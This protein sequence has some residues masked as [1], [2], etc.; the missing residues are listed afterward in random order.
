MSLKKTIKKEIET[1]FPK[2]YK[3]KNDSVLDFY[4]WVNTRNFWAI[5]FIYFVSV[6]IIGLYTQFIDFDFLKILNI[7]FEDNIKTFTT[8][9]ITLVSMNL[10]VTNLLFTHLKDERDDIQSIIDKKVNFKFI[11]YLGFSIIVCILSLY[12]FSPNIFN[13]NVKSNI[14]IF[15]FCSFLCYIFLLIIL[16]NTVFNF[17]HKTKRTEIIKTELKLE[18]HKAFYNDYYKK[19]FNEE[20]K[21]L[22]ENK[23]NFSHY[24]NWR[25]I[26]GIEH[27]KINNSKDIYLEDIN[28]TSNQFDKVKN[29]E[30]FY[31]IMELGK[32][33]QKNT[34]IRLFSVSDKIKF[35]YK[36]FYS[37]STKNS[38]PLESHREYLDKLLKKVTDNTLTNRYT[39]L[40][41][42]LKSL[43]D[44]YSEYIDLKS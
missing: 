43:E 22:M 41:T 8:G 11:T 40:S 13:G 15:I 6:L 4:T 33:Y 25:E 23:L 30:K 27:L 24:S 20:Y 29:V 16:Y 34:D 28:D 44:I 5:L 26:E 38:F 39:D 36:R 9:I 7:K 1:K 14:L 19:R 31:H 12:F 42:N 32:Q 10:F 2:I 3:S 18:F 17:I 37:F 35:K 21:N